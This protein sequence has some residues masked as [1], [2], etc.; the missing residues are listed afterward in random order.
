LILFCDFIPFNRQALLTEISDN[1]LKHIH[2]KYID[3]TD[4]KLNYWKPC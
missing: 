1:A 4:A 3:V 2:S